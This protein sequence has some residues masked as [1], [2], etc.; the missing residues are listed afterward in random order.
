MIACHVF[1]HRYRFS[2]QGRVMAWDCQ[3]CGRPGGTK[4][5]DSE[6][7]ALVYAT[8]FDREDSADLGRRAPLLG[9][10]PLRIAHAIR[11]RS[12]G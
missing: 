7:S 3:R 6:Q 12:G 2:A 11:R 5:Y 10:F 4:M 1:G 9:M 8:A